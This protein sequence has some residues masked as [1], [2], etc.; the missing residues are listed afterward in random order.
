V[1][2]GPVVSMDQR[3]LV[4]ANPIRLIWCEANK[5]TDFAYGYSPCNEVANPKTVAAGLMPQCDACY[6]LSSGRTVD[7]TL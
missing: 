3:A 1:G 7:A 2:G 6:E 4:S 5:V